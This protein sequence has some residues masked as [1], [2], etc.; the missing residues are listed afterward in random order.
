M[1]CMR[2]TLMKEVQLCVCKAALLP[3]GFPCSHLSKLNSLLCNLESQRSSAVGEWINAA[4]LAWICTFLPAET[5]FYCRHKHNRLLQALLSAQL[6]IS[7]QSLKKSFNVFW[8]LA[9][10]FRCFSSTQY[11]SKTSAYETSNIWGWSEKIV[12]FTETCSKLM[13]AQIYFN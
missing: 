4:H 13:F 2:G 3:I 7:F 12:A 10:W 9:L 6:H 1:C 5:K 8:F 11:T